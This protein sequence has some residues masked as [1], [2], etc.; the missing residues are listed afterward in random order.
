MIKFNL[1]QDKESFDQFVS[2]AKSFD[3]EEGDHT[4]LPVRVVSNESGPIA[5]FKEIPFPLI[6][7][8][9]HPEKCTPRNFLD[10][11]T[12]VKAWAALNSISPRF[13]N[14]NVLLAVENN[15]AIPIE[16]IEKLGFKNL[17]LQVH[18][19]NGT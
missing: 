11:C 10:I 4:I 15:P 3:H 14:G 17:G 6:C 16:I 9:F 1:I 5:Y 7:P 18:Q 2:F 8:A 13:P 19:W 12:Q